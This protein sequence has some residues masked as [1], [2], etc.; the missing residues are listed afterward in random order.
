MLN[1][2]ITAIRLFVI[3]TSIG[4][5]ASTMVNPMKNK[6]RFFAHFHHIEQKTNS[7]QFT[8][9]P[10]G[11]DWLNCSPLNFSKSLSGKI[12]VLDFWTYCCI[13]CI[14]MIPILKQMKQKYKE[15]PVEFIGVH[16]PKFEN[17]KDSQNVIEAIQRYNITHPV[18][19]DPE[20]AMWK[21]FGV[22]CWPTFIV[23]NPNGYPIYA[24]SGEGHEKELDGII[25]AAILYYENKCL[26]NR[27]PIH[28]TPRL[29]PN[30][31][32]S[33]PGKIIFDQETQSLFISDSGHHRVLITDSKGNIDSIIGSGKAGYSNGDYSEA[34]FH[35]PQGLCLYQ[36]K[37]FV[38]DTE[39][40]A[41][42]CVD[43]SHKQVDNF[44]GDGTQG[45]D[46]Q[47]GLRGEQ[48]TIS[49]PW[50]LLEIES[51]LL[52]AMSGTHQIWWASP[53][54]SRA[55]VFSG[56]GKELHLDHAD[57][58][59]SAWAQPSGLCVHKN[60]VFIA[61]SESSSIRTIDLE[62]GASKTLS[63]GDWNEP[64][65][66]FQFGD[67]NGDTTTALFQHPL[68]IIWWE[69]GQKLIIA[70]T[71]NHQIKLLDPKNN[72]VSQWLGSAKTGLKD[73]VGT[74]SL[75]SEPSGL[76]IDETHQILYVAD[77]N[78][79]AIRKVNLSTLQ[80][81]TLAIK[82]KNQTKNTVSNEANVNTV[83]MKLENPI[84]FSPHQ[85]SII[86]IE[87]QFLDSVEIDPEASL[88]NL[89]ISPNSQVS[90]STAQL[91]GQIYNSKLEIPINIIESNQQDPWELTATLVFCKEGTMCMIKKAVVHFFV[92]PVDSRADLTEK[93][94][95]I[96]CTIA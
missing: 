40:H 52:I 71:Y 35:G 16:T 50:D 39:N 30:K 69:Q 95:V 89:T 36:N 62:T 88:W 83:F 43:L 49:S 17:E 94:P 22:Q 4:I 47:G 8:G 60:T 86:N 75:F 23:I 37:L 57:P 42:R 31:T 55:Q 9:F 65:N 56:S 53:N 96:T 14:H 21:K 76:A 78:N 15:A 45:F 48:Q 19:N 68:A 80:V 3:L 38:A 13:N 70:D 91:S 51:N 79:H 59:K 41:I 61:D 25:E 73:G 92:V 20:F 27:N 85:E 44:L 64:R 7:M 12:I 67:K 74:E 34:S 24:V 72:T 32:L 54:S 18:V 28:I 11:L 10:D 84:T 81:E 6:A 90:Q 93:N 26:F 1:L 58:L 82:H 46:Y 5:S 77:T 29:A 33:Y 63:G 66:L 87:F 2:T